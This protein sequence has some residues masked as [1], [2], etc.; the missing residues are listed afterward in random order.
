[1]K[2][3]FP[4]LLCCLVLLGCQSNPAQPVTPPEPTQSAVLPAP[5]YVPGHPL[6]QSAPEALKVYP[7]GLGCSG[8]AFPG[9]KAA[10]AV[11]HGHPLS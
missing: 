2:R 3:L 5:E 10:S 4:L 7:P 1:M 6:A 9:G 8:G 11:R